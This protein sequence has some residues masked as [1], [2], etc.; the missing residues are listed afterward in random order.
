MSI[1]LPD[2]LADRLK[3]VSTSESSSQIIQEALRRHLGEPLDAPYAR[4]PQNADQLIEK[5]REQ[6]LPAAQDEYERGFTA[7]LNRV[8]DLPWEVLDGLADRKFDVATWIHPWINGAH[9]IAVGKAPEGAA[10]PEWLLRI[11]EDLGQ[12]AGPI[13]Y[14]RF[15]FQRSKMYVR[16]YGDA[17]KAAFDAVLSR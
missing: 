9:D 10:I 7:A 2:D 6:L 16:G 3:L 8:P 4:P 1:Y 17:L 11:A 14:D 15:S 5:A 12:L 13:G